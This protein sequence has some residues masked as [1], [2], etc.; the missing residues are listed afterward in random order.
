MLFQST[1]KANLT[2]REFVGLGNVD[3]MHDQEAIDK[4]IADAGADEIIKKLKYGLDTALC[5]NHSWDDAI[6]KELLLKRV[7]DFD[8]F[9]HQ[10]AG[11]TAAKEQ[12]DETKDESTDADGLRA[13]RKATVGLAGDDAKALEARTKQALRFPLP[14]PLLNEAYALSDT[15]EADK[16]ETSEEARF[17]GGEVSRE[18]QRFGQ[19]LIF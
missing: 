19:R 18:V 8:T 7:Q 13:L 9:L 2:V 6:S 15:A 5:A 1:P 16:V 4:A 14:T 12:E 10:R 11:L 17:S 3:L